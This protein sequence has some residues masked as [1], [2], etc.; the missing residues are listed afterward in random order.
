MTDERE[1]NPDPD[2]AV[3]PDDDELRFAPPLD[4]PDAAAIEDAWAAVA[5]DAPDDAPAPEAF[6]SAL[7]VDAALA[8]VSRLDDIL[9]EEEAAEQARLAREQAAADEAAQ[10]AA[11]LKHPEYFF[12]MPP[13]LITQRGRA[14]AVVPA[15]ALIGIG[16]W[17]TF[18]LT[19]SETPPDPALVLAVCAAA[20]SVTLI[21]RWLA[22]GRWAR[23]A[24]LLAL[25][26]A[27]GAAAL[28]VAAA[29]PGLIAGWPLLLLAPAVAL[30]GVGLLARP[31]QRRL[32]LPAAL[33]AVT[34]LAGLAVTTGAISADIQAQLVHLWPAAAAAVVLALALPLLR[35]R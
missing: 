14:D 6:D 20:I 34:A 27:G 33:L 5:H 3:P 29:G 12:A 8:A 18:A 19:T 23:G 30:A 11:R 13:L 1:L 35:R 24:L 28:Y 25:L 22:T 2:E 4:A 32:L 7:D 9:A 31:A 16:A 26:I 17:L 21:A 15:L 10:R